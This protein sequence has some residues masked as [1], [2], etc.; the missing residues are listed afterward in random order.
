MFYLTYRPKTI[1][2]IDNSQVKNIL[3]NLLAGKNLPHAFLFVGQ[4]GTGKTSVARIIAK[5]VNC[6]ENAFA[7]KDASFEPCNHCVNCKSIATSSSPDVIELDAA[8]NRGIDDVKNL[9]KEAGF[10]P[11]TG[12]YRLFII[13]EAHMITNEGFNALLK[14]LEEPPKTVIF[15]LATTNLEKIPPTIASRCTLVNFGQAG[16]KDILSMF[17]RILEK[18]KIKLDP[19]I[20]ELIAENSD[21]SFR[22]AS[23]LLEEIITQK[24]TTEEGVKNILGVY[25]KDLLKV[26]NTKDL[27]TALAWINVFSENGG[28][29]KILIENMLAELRICLLNKNGLGEEKSNL[30]FSLKEIVV[31][32]KLLTEAY[33]NLRISPITSLPLEIAVVEFYNKL[34]IK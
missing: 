4:K 5:T 10:M 1:A 32:M 12:K 31:L 14:T 26:I 11:M 30:E 7:K 20:L 15:I 24:I 6:L 23:K 21:H 18:E 3:N 22:D 25:Q 27:K 8:S 17:K 19:K 28:N 34:N 33:Q 16:V 13:D 9:V 29:F 2:E